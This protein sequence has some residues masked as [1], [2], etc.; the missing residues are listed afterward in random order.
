M[1]REEYVEYIGKYAPMEDEVCWLA[2][3]GELSKGCY[4]Q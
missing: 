4:L 3:E 1:Y 2:Q